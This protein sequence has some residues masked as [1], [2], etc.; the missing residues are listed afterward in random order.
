MSVDELQDALIEVGCVAS[1]IDAE[2]I[3]HFAENAIRKET[4]MQVS[5]A[6]GIVDAQIEAIELDKTIPAE[7]IRRISRKTKI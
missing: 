2:S 3:G 4:D 1:E 5:K 7:R 6:Q